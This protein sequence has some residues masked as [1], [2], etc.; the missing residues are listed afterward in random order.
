MS[1]VVRQ[2]NDAQ[3]LRRGLRRSFW[4]S[5]VPLKTIAI[6][7][8]IIPTI[9]FNIEFAIKFAIKPTHSPLPLKPLTIKLDGVEFVVISSRRGGLRYRGQSIEP[10]VSMCTVG[11]RRMEIGAVKL[12]QVPPKISGPNETR[13][14]RTQFMNFILLNFLVQRNSRSFFAPFLLPILQR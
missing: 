13:V 4:L 3:S 1:E 12:F 2:S 8:N 9:E 5:L 7:Y 6:N 14:P 10:C 11:K